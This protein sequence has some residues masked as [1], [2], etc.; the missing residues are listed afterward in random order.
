[1]IDLF[2][3]LLP[4]WFWA[5]LAA[6]AIGALWLAFGWRSALVA[7]GAVLPV[8]GFRWAENMGAE[9]ERAKR[10][11]QALDHVR[12]RKESDDEIDQMG[13]SDVDRNLSR[14]LRDHGDE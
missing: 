14:W 1:M 3:S 12:I 9:R 6:A 5:I 13:S 2:L 7:A 10:D 8:L 4:W 11:R